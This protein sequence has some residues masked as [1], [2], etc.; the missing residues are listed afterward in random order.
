M[1]A[2]RTLSLIACLLLAA[3]RPGGDGAPAAGPGLAPTVEAF[4][5]G[6]ERTWSGVLPC[7]DCQGVEVRLVLRLKGGKRSYEML[8]TYVGGREPNRFSS[9]GDWKETAG[10]GEGQSLAIYTINPGAAAQRFALQ[11]DGALLMLDDEG[12]PLEPPVAYRLQRL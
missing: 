11:A 1:S 10:R 9:E 8:E 4:S 5:E 6:S 2:P 3:C 7:S 12:R